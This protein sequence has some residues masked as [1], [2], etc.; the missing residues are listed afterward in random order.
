MADRSVIG[1]II[2]AKRD[3]ANAIFAAMGRGPNT[4]SVPLSPTGNDPATHYGFN[5][6]SMDVELANIVA[7]LPDNSGTLPEISGTWGEGGLP[8][9]GQA[10]AACAVMKAFLGTNVT[11]AAH[12]DGILSGLV[13]QEISA[14]L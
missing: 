11:G 6:E 14:D 2:A 5:D 9:E 1:I 8:S 7:A 12:R 10:R 3:D 13:L 4:F